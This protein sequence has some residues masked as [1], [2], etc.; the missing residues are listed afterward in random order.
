VCLCVR[1]VGGER[2]LASRELACSPEGCCLPSTT[3]TGGGI[4]GT[5]AGQIRTRCT[6]EARMLKVVQLLKVVQSTFGRM[7]FGACWCTRAMHKGKGVLFGKHAW[8]RKGDGPRARQGSS[9]GSP[10]TRP[11]LVTTAHC[12]TCAQN[13]REDAHAGVLG[14]GASRALSTTALQH[15][16]GTGLRSEPL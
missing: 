14:E 6:R 10:W 11:A 12:T 9:P 3:T 1:E 16:P 13:R 5:G 15:G 7:C 8:T 2:P 4:C